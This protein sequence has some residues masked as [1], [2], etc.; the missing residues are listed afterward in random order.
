VNGT[1]IE[2]LTTKEEVVAFIRSHTERARVPGSVGI[3]A[4]GTI[5]HQ[6]ATIF[7]G[8]EGLNVTH[9]MNQAT[10]E[11]DPGWSG[12][13]AAAVD[14]NPV[15]T[16]V[17]GTV[18]PSADRDYS[19]TNVQVEDVDEADFIKT[20][21]TNIYVVIGNCMHIVKA[22]PAKD[23][24]IL[25]TLRFAGRPSALYTSGDRVVLIATDTWTRPISLCTPGKC[26]WYSASKQRTL[27]YVFSMKNASD[28]QLVRELDIDGS[29]T[30][31]RMI[32]TQLYFV[33]GT[34]IPYQIED[35]ELPTIS[36]DHGGITT[37][38]VYG[39][40]TIDRAFTFST[41]GSLDVA[42]TSA[43]PA[44]SFIVGMAGTVYVSPARLY[45]AATDRNW[46][47]GARPTTIHAFAID[48]GTISYAASGKVD[49]T[50]LNQYS[51]DE[52]N[53]NLRVATTIPAG[54]SQGKAGPYSQVTVLDRNLAVLGTLPDIAPTERI[55]A[56][57]FM[58]DRLYLVTFRETDPFFVIG[59]ADPGQP[60][61]LG[62]LK[63]P[64][65]SSY[66]HPYDQ[67]HI[68]G[69][70]KETQNGVVKMALF[71]V[72]DVSN[73]V[74]K[75]SE[76]LGTTYSTSP[77]LDDPKAFLFD[78]EKNLLVLPVQLDT[79]RICPAKGACLPANSWGGAYV[80]GVN[81]QSGFVPKGTVQHY[82]STYG[83]R[84]S[85]FTSPVKRSLYI[86]DTLYTMAD[87]MIMMS[88]LARSLAEV[89][90]VDFQ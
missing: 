12:W 83:N 48:N 37:P 61:V 87:D 58:G 24:K 84:G 70:G 81:P 38:P 57:R 62:E 71:D 25:S 16:M 78:R 35:L 56:A 33:T 14:L 90:V 27:V 65:Y 74:L 32:G 11:S 21:G 49:G 77:V 22:Y 64:G 2:Q 54:F 4:N 68:I 20:D 18:A 29:Y 53:G 31:S 43:V 80:Y 1:R 76:S 66:L 55:Y 42:G 73:P 23:A 30:S 28:P 67:D 41:I 50:L 82:N 75:D 19:K 89:N 3:F 85:G 52:Y 45:I 86:D 5:I 15:P 39:F 72:S 10:S 60:V 46:V 51:L 6:G 88:D 47:P 13:T 69:I 34:S 36:D 63:I 40:D 79:P 7:I 26:S 44:K 9:A 8:E 59:L 17:P